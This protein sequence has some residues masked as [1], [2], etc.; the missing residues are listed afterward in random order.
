MFKSGRLVASNAY[1]FA[2]AGGVERVAYGCNAPKVVA[3]LQA[4]AGE[5]GCLT[6]ASSL[7]FWVRARYFVSQRHILA[8]QTSRMHI[9]NRCP[10]LTSQKPV[11]VPCQKRWQTRH[12]LRPTDPR[13]GPGLHGRRRALR[14]AAPFT[15]D[16]DDEEEERP[17]RAAG[18][19]PP[20]H[21][22]AQRTGTT[23]PP[24]RRTPP[25]VPARPTEDLGHGTT[26]SAFNVGRLPQPDP[27]DRGPPGRA[28]GRDSTEAARR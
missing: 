4:P 22:A 21:R 26:A 12:P 23:S 8:R 9:S 13:G 15:A 6:T 3:Q 16:D 10:S 18:A 27:A 24:S 11:K 20:R 25:P 14:E 19:A 2:R 5:V 17:P 1:G 28:P 7:I